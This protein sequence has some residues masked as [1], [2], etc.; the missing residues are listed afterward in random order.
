MIDK[1]IYSIDYIQN[2]KNKYNSDP[3]LIERAL[4]AFGLLEA[5]KSVGM[6]FCFKGGTSL[7][8]ILDKPT[9][10]STD[11][12][13]IVAPE[14]NV[15]EYIEKAAKIFPFLKKEEDIRKGKNGIIKRHFKFTYFSPVRNTDFYILLDIV[16]SP[17]PYAKTIEK[18]IKNELLLTS[19][20]N[21]KVRIPTADCILGDKLTAFAPHTTG[22]LLGKDRELEIAKQLY[23]TAT[24]IDYL[25]DYDL[26]SATY[27]T[28]VIEETKFRGEEWTWQYVLQDTIRACI[29]IISRGMFD[30]EDYAE[31]LR[32]IKSLK[33]HIL[34]PSYNTDEATWKACK[35][36][37]LSSCL[38][39]EKEHHK[40][41]NI[42]E[43]LEQKL[44]MEEY[45]KLSYVRKQSVEAYANLVEATRI[46]KKR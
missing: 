23:D 45:K 1:R 38:L 10:L 42:E 46:L 4:Y 21:L 44:E 20:E 40:L 43:Y 31:Y 34:L 30:K 6:S 7:M 18:E 26:F 41:I 15:D 24:L 33:N 17:L 37:Y 35:V 5:I 16:F 29:S 12:D 28:A 22:I 9:R 8:L 39:A 11:I 2:L 13:I 25:N 36:L 3:G 32:G 19:G 14:T 27:K